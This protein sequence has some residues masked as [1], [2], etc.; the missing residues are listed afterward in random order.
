MMLFGDLLQYLLESTKINED[1]IG[2]NLDFFKFPNE[3]ELY[4]FQTFS[5]ELRVSKK[6]KSDGIKNC[7]VTASAYSLDSS[8]NYGG[9]DLSLME[10]KEYLKNQITISGD[11]I[12]YSDE[13]GFVKFSNLSISSGISQTI[14]LTFFAECGIESENEFKK[15]GPSQNISLKSIYSNSTTAQISF[16]LSMKPTIDKFYFA[17]NESFNN[18]IFNFGKEILFI[19]GFS[20]SESSLKNQVYLNNISIFSIPANRTW[21]YPEYESYFFVNLTSSSFLSNALFPSIKIFNLLSGATS[22]KMNLTSFY[23]GKQMK[24]YDP[25]QNSYLSENYFNLN[26]ETNVSKIEINE[27]GSFIVKEG[28]IF[29]KPWEIIVKD[30]EN[31]TIQNKPVF[32]K[33]SKQCNFEISE[34]QSPIENSKVLLNP[35]SFTN[36]FGIATFSNLKFSISGLTKNNCQ[37]K[38]KFISDGFF[39]ETDNIQVNSSINKIIWIE[40]VNSINIT[41]DFKIIS[42]DTWP[43]IQVQDEFG[44]GI[45][46]KLISFN[47][48]DFTFQPYQ[49]ITNQNGFVSLYLDFALILPNNFNYDYYSSNQTC[50]VI[51]DGI[52]SETIQIK[53]NANGWNNPNSSSISKIEII[54]WNENIKSGELINLNI[55]IENHTGIVINE[56]Y[57]LTGFINP[58]DL[59]MGYLIYPEEGYWNII[60]GTGIIFNKN[61]WNFNEN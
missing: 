17:K 4:Y 49:F 44:K 39:I 30:N 50:S 56:N 16:P 42:N 5:T 35:I 43:V 59:P 3:T 40:T 6:F 58:G 12:Q 7:K 18:E 26:F 48:S 47:C 28:E 45:P 10:M 19:F 9:N 31:K 8:Q 54:N 36:E 13:D 22:T 34:N 32:A 29:S 27:N 51:I 41:E 11:T 25:S 1:K 21:I 23:E 53:I 33:I 2:I 38:I 60:N 46:N 61:L 52:E 57:N 20:L 15:N 55:S 14:N 37:F 24:I